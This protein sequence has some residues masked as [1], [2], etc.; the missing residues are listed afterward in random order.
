MRGS[1]PMEGTGDS[2]ATSTGEPASTSGPSLR[3]LHTGQL[4]SGQA[5]SS[6]TDVDVELLERRRHL[7]GVR[8]RALNERV[9][10]LD[11]RETNLNE[12]EA[13]LNLREAE[14]EIATSF[15]KEAL[16]VR[17]QEL[18]ELAARLER[19]EAQVADYVVQAQRHLAQAATPEPEARPSSGR[20]WRRH[21]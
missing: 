17:E 9:A 21:R 3:V 4:S 13:A 8:E 1:A 18:N 11:R 6:G 19:K 7:V 5:A 2:R 14:H 16:G 12:R 15:E 10:E 20:G